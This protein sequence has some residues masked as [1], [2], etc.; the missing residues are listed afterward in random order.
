MMM[1]GLSG[2]QSTAMSLLVCSPFE[3][4]LSAAR[5]IFGNFARKR[6]RPVE[7]C[8]HPK[9]QLVAGGRRK[10]PS[11]HHGF[12]VTDHRARSGGVTWV[13]SEGFIQ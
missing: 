4:V 10:H 12:Q 13:A 2:G 5:Q 8:F 3:P 7:A 9:R 6:S 1:G 11:E